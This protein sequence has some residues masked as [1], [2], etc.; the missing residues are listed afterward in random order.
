MVTTDKVEFPFLSIAYRRDLDILFCRWK[1]D[2]ELYEFTEGY[3]RSLN[4]AGE[5]KAYYWLEDIRL[6]NSVP[7]LAIKHWFENSFVTA[8]QTTLSKSTYMAYLLS[9]R[10]LDI[11]SQFYMG[12]QQPYIQFNNQL[13]ISFFTKEQE[14]LNWL[15][16]CKS[17]SLIH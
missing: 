9:P 6:H 11:I 2:V 14:A 12:N 7:D 16:G 4:M 13:G 1:K 5:L 3:T 10:Q 17:Q 8:T 15:H